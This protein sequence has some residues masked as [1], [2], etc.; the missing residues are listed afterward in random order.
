VIQASADDILIFSDTIEHLNLLTDMLID[1]VN[2]A[3]INFNPK[4]FKLLIHKTHKDTIVPIQLP[5]AKEDLTDM[6]ICNIEDIVKHLSV[7]L[8]TRKLQKMRFNYSE[9]KND[10]VIKNNKI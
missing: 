4:K 5:D 1:C 6:E 3:H 9:L 2:Y 8:S 7:Q 10:Q